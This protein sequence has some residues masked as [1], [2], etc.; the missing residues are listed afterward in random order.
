M[1]LTP[2][3]ILV[4]L[5][6]LIGSV[7]IKLSAQDLEAALSNPVIMQHYTAE[8]LEELARVDSSG[9][10]AVLYYFTAT[11]EVEAIRCYDC[12]PFDSATFDVS[13]YEHLRK[14]DTIYVRE[15]DKYG[16]K[17]TLYPI[18]ALEYEYDIHNVPRLDPGD[19][20]NQQD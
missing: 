3:G 18:N 8:Q 20:S 14:V 19:K 15:F 1:N 2:S 13:R 10:K 17:L 16:F 12:L 9:L 6:F 5:I 11:Y 4:V 7:N